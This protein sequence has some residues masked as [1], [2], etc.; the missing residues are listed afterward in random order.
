MGTA[1][2]DVSDRKK[3]TD[4]KE[5]KSTHTQKKTARVTTASVKRNKDVSEENAPHATGEEQEI[6]QDLA[7]QLRVTPRGGGYSR[8]FWIG[9]CREGS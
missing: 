8:E 1:Q 7:V 2:S 4:Q 5:K 6:P 9:V 3:K